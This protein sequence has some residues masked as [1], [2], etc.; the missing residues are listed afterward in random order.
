M[1][2]AYVLTSTDCWTRSA[3]GLSTTRCPLNAPVEYSLQYR[4]SLVALAW[5]VQTSQQH[6]CYAIIHQ[7]LNSNLH[8]ISLFLPSAFLA[9]FLPFIFP[10]KKLSNFNGWRLTAGPSIGG[11]PSFEGE[12]AATHSCQAILLRNRNTFESLSRYQSVLSNVIHFA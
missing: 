3:N 7:L 11:G 9:V 6:V 8:I 2:A 4:L 12:P 5:V 1:A 10:S